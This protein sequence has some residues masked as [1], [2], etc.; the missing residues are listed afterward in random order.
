MKMR[1]LKNNSSILALLAICGLVQQTSANVVG[2]SAE[3]GANIWNLN[4]LRRTPEH[5]DYQIEYAAGGA[6]T[7][8]NFNLCSNTYTNCTLPNGDFD[9]DFAHVILKKDGKCHRLTE[10]D[11]DESVAEYIDK[12]N[13]EV[14][15]RLVYTSLEKCDEST[16]GEMWGFTLDIRCDEDASNPIPR[17]KT[18]SVAKNQCHPVVYMESSSGCISRSFSKLWAL[19]ERLVDELGVVLII[20]GLFLTFLGNKYNQITLF[21]AGFLA[22]S[23]LT[24]FLLY[25]L[26]LPEFTPNWG[27]MVAFFASGF[28]GVTLGMFS[29]M[30]TKLGVFL[31][32]GW[33]GGTTGMMV[34]NSIFTK[35]L[36]AGP[37]AQY[38]FWAVIL[39]FVA[40][41]AILT[42]Y[43]F[44]HAIAIGS[45]LVGAYF[46]VR[47][48][49]IFIGG[50]PNE[51]LVY[52]E[53]SNGSYAAMP[54]EFYIYLGVYVL[55]AIIGLV[56]QERQY[57]QT[58]YQ[59]RKER[60]QGTKKN[61]N[62]K[63]DRDQDI[64]EIKDDE[65]QKPLIKK[66][67]KK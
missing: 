65:D 33:L 4:P 47:G 25:G 53:I 30:F 3:V 31:L 2:C 21:L 37:K 51:Y 23:F 18:E 54:D 9:E 15:L 27:H 49:G 40:L 39:L 48:A 56:Y 61:K 63:G 57:L 14:G 52:Q 34:Y 35:I 44:N 45:S 50:F 28:A 20:L 19:G 64:E 1:S 36:E 32:G 17:I 29:A 60:K 24:L 26:I 67:N 58:K 6:Q 59:E 42:V 8:L 62:S 7:T 66:K 12:E 46:L 38:G 43:L 16:T 55:I 41:G 22:G 10:D 5:G 11:M 13:P